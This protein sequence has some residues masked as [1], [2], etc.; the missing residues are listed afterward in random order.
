VAAAEQSSFR[1]GAE[2]VGLTPAALSQRIKQLEEMLECRLFDRSSRRVELTPQGQ[3]LLE[4]ARVALAELHACTAV[5][6]NDALRIRMSIGTRFELGMSW[7]VPALVHLRSAQPTWRIDLVFGS[8]REILQRLD[9][10]T[11][12]AIVTSA[13]SA[14]AEW[15]A[16][17]LHPEHYVLVGAPDLL[18]RTA[19]ASVAD[20]AAHTLLDLD[21]DLPLTRYLLAVCPDL[22]FADVWRVGT[23]A[24]VKSLT[25]GGQGLAVLP[26]YMV[27]AELRDGVLTELLPQTQPLSDTFRLLH[28]STSS[29]ADVLRSLAEELR[30]WPL[31]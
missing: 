26:R 18:A 29:M 20:A 10:G 2:Q 12:D 4:R 28:R 27:R 5:G 21:G 25:L 19:C 30:A 16:H 9:G 15:T 6:G 14:S 31:R 7:L 11:V 17:V 13:P 23:G 8:G 24:A 22:T 1:R 3:G